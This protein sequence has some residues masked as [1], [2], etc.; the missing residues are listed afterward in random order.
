M[1]RVEPAYFPDLT[2]GDEPDRDDFMQQW[3]GKHL[4]SMQEARVFSQIESDTIRLLTLPTFHEPT[5]IRIQRNEERTTVNVKRT[6]GRGGYGPGVVTLDESSKHERGL[7]EAG[8]NL[9][10]DMGFWDLPTLDDAIVLDGTRYVIESRIDGAYHVLERASP[11]NPERRLLK[12][13]YS[14]AP[15]LKPPNG[16]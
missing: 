8:S 4:R 6:N 13:L 15:Q 11:K 10:T 12:W 7:F 3:F 5:L 1:T 9:L 16:G 14:L 2:F